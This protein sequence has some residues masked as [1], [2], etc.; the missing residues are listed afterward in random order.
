MSLFLLLELRQQGSG[1]TT[2]R[3]LVLLYPAFEQ[4]ARD[5]PGSIQQKVQPGQQTGNRTETH[6]CGRSVRA[7]YIMLPDE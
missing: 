3:D 7:R 1:R 4:V 2:I 6:R 5:A